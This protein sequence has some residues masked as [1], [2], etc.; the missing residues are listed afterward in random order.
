M[1]APGRRKS[2]SFHQDFSGAE[3]GESG[4]LHHLE[5]RLGKGLS[6]QR[7]GL[8][9]AEVM[10]PAFDAPRFHMVASAGLMRSTSN[11]FI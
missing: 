4:F 11:F 1:V 10:M 3:F 9:A 6:H 2:N 7:E 5:I 8:G